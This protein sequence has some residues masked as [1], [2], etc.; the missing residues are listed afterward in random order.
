MRVLICDD[1]QLFSESLAALFELEGFTTRCVGSPPEALNDLTTN[2]ADVCV[3]DLGFDDGCDGLSALEDIVGSP[4][5]V[6][7]LTGVDDTSVIDRCRNAGAKGFVA[8]TCAT[9][10]V[11]DAVK[12][13]ADEDSQF[14]VE[15]A[16]GRRAAPARTDSFA[17]ASL[18]LRSLTTREREVLV[19]L[20]HGETAMAMAARTGVS[21]ATAR[22]HIQRVL[23]KLGV[24]S[25]TEAIG[26]AVRLGI[27][28]ER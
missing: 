12:R 17:N 23:T 27:V 25:R 13:A 7:V 1:H 6:V 9:E 11:V 18:L 20:V 21:Y 14:F 15:T 8:K 16:R 10:Q 2:G 4:T 28:P 26:F 24:H 3:L 5:A 19:G 22:S